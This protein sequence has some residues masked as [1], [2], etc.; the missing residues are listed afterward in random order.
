MTPAAR[1]A[2][3]IEVLDRWQ[4]G[5]PVS[6]ALTAWG[7]GARY[8]GSKDRAAVQD[9]V[10]DVL[11][12]KGRCA[13]LGGGETGRALILGLL[14]LGGIDPDAVFTGQGH[15]PAALMPTERA[16]PAAPVAPELDIPNWLRPALAQRFGSEVP[17]AMAALAAR[18]PVFLRTNTRKTTPEAVLASLSSDGITAHPTDQLPTALHVTDGARRIRTCAAYRDG[19]VE[20]QDLSAQRA[21]AR[22]TWPDAGKI[23]DY[24]AGGGGKSLAIAMQS[25]A[26]LFAHDAIP[27]RMSDLPERARRAGARITILDPAEIARQGPFDAVLC[28]VPCSGSGTWRRDP[29]A[30]WRLTRSALADLVESQ[31]RILRDASGLVAANGYLVYMTCSLFEAENEAQIARFLSETPG[32]KA[33][34]NWIDTPLS[35]SDGFY[36]AVLTRVDPSASVSES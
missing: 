13:V 22:V 32:W 29:E 31:A 5:Q 12:C 20:L 26:R 19:L 18:A 15:A 30:K 4:E 3:A 1:Y 28:D 21:V 10:Y 23:L 6:R 24:C 27:R 34:S 11:R 14:R 7:R 17:A 36:T 35:A 8:A 16:G 9:H 33:V 2:A 25:R